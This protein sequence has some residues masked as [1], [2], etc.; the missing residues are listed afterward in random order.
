MVDQH[1]DVLTEATAEL[2]MA[3]TLA[4][5][6]RMSDAERDLRAGRWRGWDPGG[7]PRH[8]DLGIHRRR[9]RDGQDRPSLRRGWPTARRPDRL[10][11][12]SAKPEA[13]KELGARRLELPG[14]ARGLRRGQPHAP[15]SPRPGIDRRP[16]LELI[17][18]HGFWSTPRGDRW[19]SRRPSP[20]HS[21]A[22][23]SAPPAWTSTRTSPSLT[24]LAGGAA[25][26][27]SPA[28]RLGDSAGARWDGERGRGQRDRCARGREPPSRVA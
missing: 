8:R 19:S 18:P 28:H 15:P 26:R 9:G 16:Q 4:A 12:P 27:P 23:H 1:A 10:R 13:E 22:G 6:R 7:L 11:G 24:A 14:P 20:R 21:R 17:G 2:A 25:L 3:L 5:A